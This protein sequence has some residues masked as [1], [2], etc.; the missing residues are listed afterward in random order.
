MSLLGMGLNA[1]ASVLES[2]SFGLRVIFS[3]F[4]SLDLKEVDAEPNK[5]G[6]RSSRDVKPKGERRADRAERGP[7]GTC[8]EVVC[9][10]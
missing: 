3:A 5:E 7:D 1:E 4:D 2:D 8:G 6:T 9:A 10:D